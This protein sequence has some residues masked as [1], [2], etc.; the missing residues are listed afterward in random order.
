MQLSESKTIFSGSFQLFLSPRLDVKLWW[1]RFSVKI[2]YLA[3][4]SQYPSVKPV[5]GQYGFIK[6]TKSAA[7]L[8]CRG[9]EN[10]NF[11]NC[12]LVLLHL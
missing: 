9:R 10:G 4:K 6:E 3:I 7:N 8:Q 11:R 1:F 2:N 12:A 5:P